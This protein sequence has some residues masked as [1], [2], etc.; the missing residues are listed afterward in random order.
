MDYG[1]YYEPFQVAFLGLSYRWYAQAGGGG[2]GGGWGMFPGK[3][4]KKGCI[5]CNLE[6]TQGC[7]TSLFYLYQADIGWLCGYSYV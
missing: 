5:S 2:G 4:L 1:T 3:Y 6:A 7:S